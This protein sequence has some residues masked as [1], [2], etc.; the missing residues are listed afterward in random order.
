MKTAYFTRIVVALVALF[1]SS[2]AFA[3]SDYLLELEGIK[4]ECVG[5]H[6]KLTEN[7]DGSFTAENIPSGTYKIVAK[8]NDAG[9]SV[10]GR[11]PGTVNINFECVVSPRDAASGQASGK[12][13]HASG[14]SSGKRERGS[15]L[16]T[17]KRQHKPMTISKRIDKMV[18]N[19]VSVG[20]ITVGD[21]NDGVTAEGRVTVGYDL[22]LN[23]KV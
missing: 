16:A 18:P 15:G 1:V 14:Q 21:D 11:T 12:R 20:E 3:A 17:G 7:A 5:K 6:I 8:P 23:K 4:G 2:A 10:R 13:D 22:K 19:G 9:A